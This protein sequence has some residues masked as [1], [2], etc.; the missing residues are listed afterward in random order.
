MAA[1]SLVRSI[2][3]D[4]IPRHKPSKGDTSHS[5]EQ[6]LPDLMARIGDTVSLSDPP[7]LSSPQRF[8][9]ISFFKCF[10]LKP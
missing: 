6:V 1:L 2:Y 10:C 5:L 9:N 4:W 3:D 8:Q 7:L